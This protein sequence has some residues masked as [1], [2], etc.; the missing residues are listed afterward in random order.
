MGTNNVFPKDNK[1]HYSAVCSVKQS[2]VKK[3]TYSK[4]NLVRVTSEQI[5]S[6]RSQA[7]KILIP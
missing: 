2:Y 3:E 6:G 7:Y 1:A 4:S 5:K